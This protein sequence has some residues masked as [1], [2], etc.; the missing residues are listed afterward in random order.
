VL[1]IASFSY[2]LLSTSNSILKKY[3]MEMGEYGME[4]DEKTGEYEVK[5]E[6]KK[7]W[8]V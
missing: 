8:L 4:R 6:A 5:C 3:G 7:R 2:L 1:G